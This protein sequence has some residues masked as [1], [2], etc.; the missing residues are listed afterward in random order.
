MDLFD[1]ALDRDRW[2]TLMGAAMN[3][4]VAQNAG[5]FLSS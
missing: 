1:L 3:F 2:R 5:S 4:R